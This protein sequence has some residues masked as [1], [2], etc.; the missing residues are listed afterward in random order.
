METIV[1]ER[2]WTKAKIAALNDSQ[3]AHSNF[4]ELVRIVRESNVPVQHLA[5]IHTMEGDTVVRL[6]YWA[7][8]VCRREIA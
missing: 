2:Q 4:D 6:A 3:L 5:H 8:Q 7:R 1:G